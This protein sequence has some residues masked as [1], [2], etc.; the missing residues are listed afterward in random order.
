MVEICLGMEL[1]L[2]KKYNT[3]L[4]YIIAPLTFLGQKSKQ[5]ISHSAGN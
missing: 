5:S 1:Y 2:V 3:L 4:K